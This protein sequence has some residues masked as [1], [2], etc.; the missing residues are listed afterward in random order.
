[1]LSSQQN[2]N[3]T[4]W[5][6]NP[7]QIETWRT[8]Y[9]Y[10]MSN[11][12]AKCRVVCPRQCVQ[13]EVNAEYTV[14]HLYWAKF[15]WQELFVVC[16]HLNTRPCSWTWFKQ[17]SDQYWANLQLAAAAATLFSRFQLIRNYQTQGKLSLRY[18]K[19][20]KIHRFK[21]IPL[22]TSWIFTSDLIFAIWRV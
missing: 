2:F 16:L 22:L 15:S 12:R 6:V 14:K 3:N 5:L 17:R 11:Q 9:Y 10:G 4:Y 13:P 21:L 18:F 19:K 8:S 1:M 20:P 7:H